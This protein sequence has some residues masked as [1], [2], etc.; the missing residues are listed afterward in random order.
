MLVCW[1]SPHA[2][3][4]RTAYCHVPPNTL[5]PGMLGVLVLEQHLSLMVGKLGTGRDAL[6]SFERFSCTMPRHAMLHH[7]RYAI[8]LPCR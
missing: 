2:C 5:Q 1:P 8:A 7:R 6:I 4:V 3:A